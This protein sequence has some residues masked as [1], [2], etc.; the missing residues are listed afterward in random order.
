MDQQTATELPAGPES[1]TTDS[2]GSWLTGPRRVLFALFILLATVGCD[3]A[4]KHIA[5]DKLM[6][7]PPISL[8]GDFVRFEYAE[9]TGAFLS[10]GSGLPDGM[11]FMLLGV[12]VGIVLV[13]MI[14]YMLRTRSLHV[15]ELLALALIAGGGVGNLIDRLTAGYV[16]DFVS[17]GF[18][19]LRTGIFNIADVAISTGMILFL[20]A[21][22]WAPRATPPAQ[23]P[24]AVS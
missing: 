14:V 2:T 6:M 12:L 21:R 1:G 3:R 10:L 23:T 13:V 9:N 22:L 15:T 8:L 18:E 24:D 11:R 17:M 20:L 7:S 4:A 16:I 5:Q 19:S